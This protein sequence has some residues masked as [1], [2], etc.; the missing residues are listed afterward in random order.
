MTAPQ[1]I[2]FPRPSWP[3]TVVRFRPAVC[4][5]RLCRLGDA[6]WCILGQTVHLITE[7]LSVAL[8]IL[9]PKGHSAAEGLEAGRSRHHHK[10]EAAEERQAGLYGAAQEAERPTHF[11]AGTGRRIQ[12]HRQTSGERMSEKCGD[13]PRW[14]GGLICRGFTSVV[15]LYILQP[16]WLKNTRK[17]KSKHVQ[18][19]I[20]T[21][22]EMPNGYCGCQLPLTS[23]DNMNNELII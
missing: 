1:K 9:Q 5:G 16:L 6:P 7:S 11:T 20:A 12:T 17:L 22:S 13:C 19:G 23:T 2:V 3:R 8:T 18:K 10:T 15:P 21:R 14:S 4:E